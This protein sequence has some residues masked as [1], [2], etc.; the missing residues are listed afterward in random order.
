MHP[1]RMKIAFTLLCAALL[2]AF[3]AAAQSWVP[4]TSGTTAS[5][6]GI[7]ALNAQ[8]VWV[9]GTGGTYLI[10]TDGGATWRAGKVPGAERLDFRAVWAFDDK[11]AYV[12]SIG[13][14]EQ[15]RIYTTTDGGATWKLLFTNPDAKGFF[16]GIAFWDSAHGIVAGDTVDGRTTIFTTADAGETWQRQNSPEA[17]GGA[18]GA[19]AASNTSIALYGAHDVWVGTTA[20]R[21]LHSGDNG[22]TW[23]AVTTPVRHDSQNAGIFSVAFRDALHGIAV[24]GDYSKDKEG[25]DNIAVT[26]DGGK[27]WTKPAGGPAGFRSAVAWAPDKKIWV[28]TGTSGSDV[29][30]DDGATW[31]QFDTT[32][33]NALAFVQG[34]G[35]AVGGRGRIAAFKWQ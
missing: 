24:G 10:T 12:L 23:T 25:R 2:S 28:A 35:W 1:N 16:D 8:T 11:T 26:S 32:S 33:Y 6:R 17:V 20:A 4:Q 19:F 29:S 21:V 27:T 15:S 9:S 22:R 14:G 5:F 3:D 7:H 30:T 31:K 18:E 34:A 13:T